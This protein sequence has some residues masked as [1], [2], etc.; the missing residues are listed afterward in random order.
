MLMRYRLIMILLGA[1]MAAS[2]ALLPAQAQ[3][4]SLSGIAFVD[5]NG[6]GLMDGREKPLADVE[7]SL[8]SVSAAG[9]T[10]LATAT[11]D[12]SGQ[13]AFAGLTGGT[14]AVRA[15]LPTPYVFT[16]PQA[17]GS[18]ILPASGQSGSTATF[19]L[20]EGAA[21]NCPIGA[22]R[23]SS[24]IT[25]YAFG[26][27]NA[28]GGRFS[29]EPLL[30]N[31]LI[32]LLYEANGITHT[33]TSAYTGKDGTVTI[34]DLTPGTYRMAA[35][36]PEPYVI[37]PLGNKINTF[38][39]C[40]VPSDSNYGTTAP[41]ELPFKGSIGLG[42]GGVETG[43]LSGTAWLDTD[44]N[45]R[46]DP[47]EPGFAGLTVELT[48]TELHVTRTAITDAT[49][50]Y[51]FHMLQP[52]SYQLKAIVPDGSMFTVP[53]DSLFSD[54]FVSE[55][56]ADVQVV[57]KQ[58]T[59]VKPIGVMP[60]TSLTVQAFHDTNANGLL[61]EGE[62]MFAGAKVDII[63][64]GQVAASLQT[65]VNGIAHFEPVRG[66]SLTIRCTLP[67]GQVFT[68]DGGEEGNRFVSVTASS[69][70][71]IDY[72]LPHATHS[73][74]LS[75]V[76]LPASIAGT[77]F[78]DNNND[79]LYTPDE[80]LMSGFQV[81]AIDQ[82]G[83]IAAEAITNENGQ[84]LLA[85]LVPGTYRVRVPLVPPYIVS[86]SPH[87][88]GSGME[89]KITSQTAQH[90]ET[91][92]VQLSAGQLLDRIDG[93]VFRSAVIE[94]DVLLGDEAD[95][96]AGSIGGL[97]G[98]EVVL[99][100]ED[101]A[102]VS[103][104]TVATTNDAGH[105]LLKGALPG[106][107]ALQYK[108]PQDAAY[109]QPYKDGDFHQTELFTV[110][111][112]A[113]IAADTLFVV[114]TGAVG[115]MVF[116]DEDD[117]GLFSKSDAA[118][119]GATL[120]M[121][122][123][124]TDEVFKAETG[125]DGV[126]LFEHLRPGKYMINV[127]LPENLLISYS[128]TSLVAPALSS[129]TSS[130]LTVSMGM[131]SLQHDIA[132]VSTASLQGAVYYDN[133]L[134]MNLNEGDAAYSGLT[135]NLRHE[136]TKIA[137][138][139]QTAADGT[140]ATA[141]LFPGRYTVSFTL[142]DDHLVH[143]PKNTTKEGASW[144]VE[145]AANSEDADSRLDIGLVQYGMLEG[146]VWN[147]GGT[148]E[149]IGS[150]PVTLFSQNNQQQLASTTTCPDGTW[151]FDNL[152]P[153][154]YYLTVALPDGYRFARTLDTAVRFSL[155]TSDGTVVNREYGQSNPFTLAMGEKKTGQDIGMGLMGKLGDFAW[156]DLDG[157][158]MQ[159]MGEPGVPGIVIRLYQY[160]TLAA[161]TTT[162]AYGRYLFDEL[163]PGAYTVEVTMPPE[164]KTT[165]QQND[166]PLVCSVLPESS[167]TVVRAEGI[168]VPSGSRNLNC[169]L[170]FVP[171][172]PGTLPDAMNNLPVRDWTPYV[173]VTPTR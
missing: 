71:A 116:T 109:S 41:F 31:V 61:D 67:D 34:R 85:A 129:K 69:S 86:P 57:L 45:G 165:K 59:Q 65:N 28:N 100:D 44:N 170:G 19:T 35:T 96:F 51:A 84:Y 4:A 43:S 26:D 7:V 73:S 12:K 139:A 131:Q 172:N 111:T 2:L 40:V 101:G 137:F 30:S 91:D 58:A 9:E 68:A 119:A 81:Q 95:G 171:R 52:G 146:A 160:G 142:P 140:F 50:A 38:Y 107:Y 53:G 110:D 122:H 76:T 117:D 130:E 98:V 46:R 151:R 1:L 166:Y 135:I 37:G 132:A 49:G 150:I 78:E 17:D 133:D 161:E 64:S 173:D 127:A 42:V 125:S 10:V 56:S 29:S 25:V 106:T 156:L 143:A 159:D 60:A 89:N 33:V 153:G 144:K 23:Q 154:D 112:G 13:Y 147:M 32:E 167:E 124:D 70:I 74:L 103:E 47:A 164:L 36:L 48:H 155:I 8:I 121:Q 66:G 157:D 136:L 88:S 134:D 75:G 15:L 145:T 141:P 104:Y 92:P 138:S 11:T 83:N 148:N 3:T 115:G 27:D 77:L 163:Y 99:L 93:G 72:E 80:R 55:A 152:Y 162:D 24:Y 82:A 114:K 128:P 5:T 6:N 158:G 20:P 108:L 113:E 94:G 54:G 14:Y 21:I 168:R 18:R 22:I 169:D 16:A 126:Y 102:P 39:N 87:A 149:A 79:G 97:P 62:P 90:G 118:L 63:M 123:T 120:S 105:F